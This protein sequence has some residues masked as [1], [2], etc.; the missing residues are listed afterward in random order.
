VYLKKPRKVE[1]L[2]QWD[3]TYGET[4]GEGVGRRERKQFIVLPL[5]T[6]KRWD[7]PADKYCHPS[8]ESCGEKPRDLSSRGLITSDS[9]V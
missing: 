2:N 4:I 9:Y 6:S 3:G 7:N 1:G 5:L 8:E